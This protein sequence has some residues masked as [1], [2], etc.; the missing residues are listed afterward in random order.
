MALTKEDLKL[1]G[2]VVVEVTAPMFEMIFE[3]FDKLESR[4]DKLESRMDTLE[5]EFRDFKS[6]VS[7]R[8]AALEEKIDLLQEEHVSRFEN[9]DE[10]I[11]M[12]YRLVDKLEHGTKSEKLFAKK[13][14]IKHLPAIHKAVTLIAKEYDI[15]LQ[16]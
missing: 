8:L 11:R 2:E 5:R 3:R 13:T 14:I 12:L 7:A 1:V 16:T 6:Y 15:K 4:M 9:I 10:D